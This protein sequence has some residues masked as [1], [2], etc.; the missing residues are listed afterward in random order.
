MYKT[1]KHE[2]AG[3]TRKTNAARAL[4][5]PARVEL[6]R[7]VTLMRRILEETGDAVAPR[8]LPRTMT[9]T[10][11]LSERYRQCMWDQAKG[12][13]T[14]FTASME[15]SFKRIVRGAPG[16]TSFECITLYRVNKRQAWYKR[17]LTLNWSRDED[18]EYCYP[19]KGDPDQ[20]LVP[21][22][23]DLLHLARR[24]AGHA[25][26]H[27]REPNLRHTMTLRLNANVA[28]VEDA[29]KS[30]GFK[31]WVR[32]SIL[33]RGKPVLIPLKTNT[34]H[35][36]NA[37][38]GMLK[39][40][41]QLSFKEGRLTIGLV[42]E[43][44]DAPARE[45]GDMIGLDWG[46]CSM[47]ASSNGRLYGRAFMD[48][49]RDADDAVEDRRRECA[50]AG[51]RLKTDPAYQR[52]C[53][54]IR[55]RARNEVGRILNLIVADRGV[56]ALAVE[57]LD[58]R[59][60]GLSRRMNRVLTR[61]GRGVVAVKLARLRESHGV[62]VDAVNPAYTSQECCDCSYTSKVNRQEQAWFECHAC[63]RRL[64]ADVNAARVIRGRSLDGCAWLLTARRV[65]LR[66]LHDQHDRAA[67]ERPWA[68][69]AHGAARGTP[70]LTD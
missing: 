11:P 59:G 64:N 32:L 65:I 7:D 56:E 46:I 51:I 44:P 37:G 27:K 57:D 14:A 62:R 9:S 21:V 70:P 10:T 6:Q 68:Y 1:Y 60:G 5:K 30:T 48:W 61:A 49:L 42:R 66:K 40:S 35:D 3:N 38:R 12:A 47:F 28:A 4:L 34:Y 24:I 16:L 22:S 20:E 43:E 17:E 39:R 15:S 41:V 8:Y 33:E 18:G 26:K 63:G 19:R 45:P 25:R 23:K 36:A 52:L 50:A 58:F 2:S 29:V 13:W 67:K 53:G 69:R 55:D 31:R 54:R